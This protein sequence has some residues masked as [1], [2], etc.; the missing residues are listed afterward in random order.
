MCRN[1][2]EISSHMSLTI[3]LTPL[4]ASY[5]AIV[6][7]LKMS[8]N[9]RFHIYGY[10]KKNPCF[11]FFLFPL[12]A[13]CLIPFFWRGS[14]L[15]LG[16]TDLSEKINSLWPRDREGRWDTLLSQ[17]ASLLPALPVPSPAGHQL[18]WHTD[19]SAI[20]KTCRE[21]STV[22]ANKNLSFFNKSVCFRLFVPAFQ[23]K[24]K[25]CGHE[26]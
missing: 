14:E 5:I 19:I 15:E 9:F 10:E 12:A 20:R 11:S 18:T 2:I 4:L 3:Q 22:N 26:S 23:L 1:A 16:R 6:S 8:L 21:F 7:L 13:T 17:T 25:T 24:T